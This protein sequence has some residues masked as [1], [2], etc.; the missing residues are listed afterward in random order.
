MLLQ[1]GFDVVKLE[2]RCEMVNAASA[3]WSVMMDSSKAD[4]S[5][6]ASEIMH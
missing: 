1:K 3:D 2:E 4:D 5:A 6:V